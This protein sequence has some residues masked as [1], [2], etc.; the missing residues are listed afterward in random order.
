MYNDLQA[1]EQ[2]LNPAEINHIDY[3]F[4][5]AKSGDVDFLEVLLGPSIPA[6]LRQ[7]EL[8]LAKIQGVFEVT[9]LWEFRGR[10]AEA[11]LAALKNFKGNEDDLRGLNEALVNA[12]LIAIDASLDL[13]LKHY[14]MHST[15]HYHSDQLQFPTLDV[16][17]H[18]HGRSPLKMSDFFAAQEGVQCNEQ[19]IYC[20]QLNE[21]MKA[22]LKKLQM[23][24]YQRQAAAVNFEITEMSEVDSYI[25]YLEHDLAVAKVEAEKFLD[26]RTVINNELSMLDDLQYGERKKR[27]NVLVEHF[28]ANPMSMPSV[29]RVP[30]EQLSPLLKSAKVPVDVKTATRFCTWH[31]K[32]DNITL[33]ACY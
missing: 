6:E 23:D 7:R 19:N 28:Q 31:Q 1:Q 3:A 32:R 15:A 13:L 11:K 14:E 21:A 5:A 10:L 27:F 20:V 9:D 24:R 8:L 16:H 25:T 2:H 17:D 18:K 22:A 30:L 12:E 4:L 26:K 29:Y 33:F